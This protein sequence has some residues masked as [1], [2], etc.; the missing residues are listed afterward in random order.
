[1]DAK[2]RNAA[3]AASV[4]WLSPACQSFSRKNVAARGARTP[5]MLNRRRA[6]SKMSIMADPADSKM[7]DAGGMKKE[8]KWSFSIHPD[9]A[10]WNLFRYCNNDPEDLTDPMGL[11]VTF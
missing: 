9:E 6:I 10:E 4:F 8:E 11:D 1:M 7:P 5:R 2:G 3:F